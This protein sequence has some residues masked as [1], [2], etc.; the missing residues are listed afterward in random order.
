MSID[1]NYRWTHL[2]KILE[3]ASPFAAADYEPDPEALTFIQDNCKILVVGCG[4]LGCELVKDLVLMGFLNVS[5]IDMDTIDLSNLNRQFLF[6]EKDIGSSK[7]EVAA[8]V[9]N[10]RIPGAKVKPYFCKIQDMD[11]NFYRQFNIIVL[12]LDSVIARRWMNFMVCSLLQYEDGMLGTINLIHSVFFSNNCFQFTDQSSIIPL[13][14]GGSEGFK[15]NARVIIPGMTA[16]IECTVDLF[17]PQVNFP[18]CTIANTPRLPE[19]CIEYVRVLLWSK[20]KPFGDVP[21]DGDDPNH[22]QWI[23]E[24]SL[25]RAQKFSIKGVTYRLTQGVVKRIIPA[26]A[27]TNAIIAACC[28]TEVF[29]I[30]TSCASSMNNYMVFNDVDGIYTYTYE[31]EKNEECLA[32]SRVPQK[33]SFPPDSKLSDLIDYLI[34]DPRHLMKAPAITANIGGK[35]KTLYM[36]SVASIE[37]ATKDNLKKTLT[38]LDLKD[39]QEI[40]VTDSTRPNNII[41]ILKYKEANKT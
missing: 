17:P 40:A 33:L 36:Q 15:G 22:I 20:E 41:F 5:V 19:H 3:R 12:G 1:S 7:A 14:D 6:R 4:G 34:N 16:C 25:E 26:V 35:N 28:V 37:A 18:L 27:S 2:R 21:I 23:H 39:G 32:C 13:I 29:K 31:A 9:I 24:K 8:K 10:E 11:E 38:E 30:A